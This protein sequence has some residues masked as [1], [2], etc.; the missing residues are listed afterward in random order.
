[1]C[2]YLREAGVVPGQVRSGAWV[3]PGAPWNVGKLVARGVPHD[4]GRAVTHVDEQLVNMHV[5]G[6]GGGGIRLTPPA[7]HVLA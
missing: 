4:H 1:M 5:R 6:H 7:V 2:A 3:C